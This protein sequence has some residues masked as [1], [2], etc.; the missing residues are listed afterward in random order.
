MSGGGQHQHFPIFS[1]F[2]AGGPKP[3]LYQAGRVAM[4][5]P[6]LLRPVPQGPCHIKN[7]TVLLIHYGGGKKHDGSKTL[8]QG[9]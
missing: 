5:C 1:P 8:Q 9:L 2:R 3:P 7:T 6:V 4:L